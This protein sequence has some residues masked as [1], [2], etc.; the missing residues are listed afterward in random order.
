MSSGQEKQG[1]EKV[2]GCKDLQRV[3]V[4]EVDAGGG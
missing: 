4:M 3:G 2:F 1:T